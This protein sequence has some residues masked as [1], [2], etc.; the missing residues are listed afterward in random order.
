VSN[1]SQPALAVP[2]V[3][4]S[5][6]AGRP[7]QLVW[8]NEI[9]GLT[10][11]VGADWDH[12][13]VKWA[14]AG[15]GADLH[16]EADRLVWAEPYTAVPHVLGWGRDHAGSW[17]VT[18]ALPGHNAVADRWANDP[19]TAVRAIGEGLRA[20]HDT[21]PVAACPYSWGAEQRLAG[22]QRR[23][24]DGNLGPDDFHEDHQPLSLDAA[25]ALLAEIPPV[26]QLVVC[27]GDSCAPNTLIAADGRWSAHVDLGGLGIADR[28][29]DLAVATWSTAWNY[30]PGWEQE[31]LDAYGIAP[32][33]RRTR[34]YRLLWDLEP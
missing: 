9:G 20:L 25:L 10:F 5:L 3:V 16:G 2:P 33:P 7:C 21:L 11:E 1:L 8:E 34:Y 26:D 27:H 29:A 18:A 6:A 19:R 15:T 17:L 13:F 31:L 24:A 12:C 23:A 22:V 30:G 4:A 14:P 32:D 28:W